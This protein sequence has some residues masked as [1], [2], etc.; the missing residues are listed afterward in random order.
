[1]KLKTNSYQQIPV[2]LG[3]TENGMVEIILEKTLPSKEIVKANAS[4][5]QAMLA[6]GEGE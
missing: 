3:I 5:L 2:K 4:V 1:M 6:G